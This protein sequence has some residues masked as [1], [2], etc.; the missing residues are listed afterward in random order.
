MKIL[1]LLLALVALTCQAQQTEVPLVYDVENTGSGFAPV[2]MPAP[3]QWPEVQA[4]IDRFLLGR[5]A[6]TAGISIYQPKAK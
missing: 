3:D 2:V 4:F 5:E 6:N 1:T